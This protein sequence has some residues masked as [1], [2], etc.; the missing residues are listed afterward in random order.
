MRILRWSGGQ[1]AGYRFDCPE[2]IRDGFSTGTLSGYV[3]VDEEEAC[4]VSYL[5][6]YMADFAAEVIAHG[7]MEGYDPAVTLGRLYRRLKQ[8]CR[9]REVVR[10][11]EEIIGQVPEEMEQVL[12][13]EGFAV[14][15]KYGRI[16][17]KISA[18]EGD[19]PVSCDP[20]AVRPVDGLNG[21]ERESLIA[22]MMTADEEA[23]VGYDGSLIPDL[24]VTYWQDGR[25]AACVFC[26]DYRGI[27]RADRVYVLPGRGDCLRAL[28]AH[29]RQ[30][31]GRIRPNCSD[32][33]L[34]QTSG[35][36]SLMEGAEPV[37]ANVWIWIDVG[38]D[39][40]SFRDAELEIDMVAADAREMGGIILSRLT[41]FAHMLEEEGEEYDMA[42]DVRMLPQVM[43]M[44]QSLG[45][46]Y[47]ME[48]GCKVMDMERGEFLFP[49]QTEL[50]EYED[51]GK[52]AL[53]SSRMN[54]RLERA[55]AYWD[56]RGI[57]MLKGYAA[58][59][60]FSD[61]IRWRKFFQD[62]NMDCHVA[63][64]VLASFEGQG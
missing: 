47:V 1:L 43:V 19:M 45:A 4:V 2:W 28:W 63:R 42:L 7:V 3:C 34:P 51:V 32:L 60:E 5:A 61:V 30:E 10:I 38:V 18:G 59:D 62:W 56:E 8:H 53:V 15:E 20:N 36:V 50:A 23:D 31:A 57:I 21:E 16:W 39:S 35:D 49:V 40:I 17:S 24:C 12:L 33:Y 44:F 27:I 46:D 11:E 14:Q 29:I 58:D 41:P 22:L 54:E 25:A 26:A 6:F 37:S 13:R 9:E 52:A 48:V 64:T 55:I